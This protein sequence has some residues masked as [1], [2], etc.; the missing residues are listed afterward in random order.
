MDTINKEQASEIAKDLRV[1]GLKLKQIGRKL[2][3]THGYV[4]KRTKKALVAGGVYHL[5]NDSYIPKSQRNGEAPVQANP[6]KRILDP[7]T[8]RL[9]ALPPLQRIQGILH[10]PATDEMKLLMIQGI[11]A[12]E[13]MNGAGA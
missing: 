1:Q 3:K 5:I 6:K 13:K 4:S 7:S 10:M 12:G 9:G 2:A 8:R 11:I